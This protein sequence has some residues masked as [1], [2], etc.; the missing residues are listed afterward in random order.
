MENLSVRT[1]LGENAESLRKLI[2][3]CMLGRHRTAQESSSSTGTESAESFGS[4]FGGYIA[5]LVREG[6]QCGFEKEVAEVIRS[7]KFRELLKVGNALVFAR[8]ARTNRDAFLMSP[9]ASS[10]LRLMDPPEALFENGYEIREDLYD[11]NEEFVSKRGTNRRIV[12]A[13]IYSDERRV[14]KITWSLLAYAPDATSPL[15]ESEEVIWR[16]EDDR[17]LRFASGEA[18][19]EGSFQEFDIKLRKQKKGVAGA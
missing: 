7:H 2:V 18:F 15:L 17:P 19:D 16:P 4:Q 5:D 13:T 6:I 10:L 3:R 8:R 12:V 14:D 11:L 1:V 9:T